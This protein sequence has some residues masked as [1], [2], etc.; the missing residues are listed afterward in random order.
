VLA[1][2]KTWVGFI[3]SPEGIVQKELRK[4]VLNPADG[5]GIGSPDADTSIRLNALYARDY[6]V[7][8]DIRIIMKS[9][10]KLGR[11]SEN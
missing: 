6:K 1:G 10:S 9:V 11:N 5:P 2:K 7:N 8:K 4:G 3:H